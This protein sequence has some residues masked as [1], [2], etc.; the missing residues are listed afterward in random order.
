MGMVRFTKLLAFAALLSAVPVSADLTSGISSVFNDVF[1]LG[2]SNINLLR[3][4]MGVI[5]VS[6][7]YSSFIKSFNYNKPVAFIVSAVVALIGVRFMPADLLLRLATFIWILLLFAVPYL[8]LGRIFPKVSTRIVVAV[9]AAIVLVLLFRDYLGFSFDLYL[10][11]DLYY[12]VA[13]SPY[14]LALV[15][16]VIVVAVF[17]FRYVFKKKY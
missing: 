5:I 8:L 11:Q 15:I 14:M 7:L 3:L 13:G 4:M 17:L 16:S 10:L 2:A 6:V 12:M 1:S 9:I